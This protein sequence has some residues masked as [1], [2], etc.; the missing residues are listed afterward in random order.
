MDKH[1][2]AQPA[3]ER[4]RYPHLRAIYPE[5][6]AHIDHLFHNRHD[7]ANTPV[8]YLAHRVIHETYPHLHGEDVR[9]LVNAIER[10]H[11][12][13]AEQEIRH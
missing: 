3:S 2:E 1:A 10:M 8:D 4:R 5:A 12:A 11:Q 13:L 6:L 9:I 7:W